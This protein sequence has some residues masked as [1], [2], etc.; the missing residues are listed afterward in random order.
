VLIGGFAV[1][2]HGASRF[3]AINRS[4]LQQLIDRRR[5]R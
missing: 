2:A 3:T 1:L 5:R 4:F